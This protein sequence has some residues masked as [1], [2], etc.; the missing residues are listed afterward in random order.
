MTATAITTNMPPRQ[1]LA[2]R[3]LLLVALLAFFLQNF[4]VQTHVHR[5][6]LAQSATSWIS[7][8][9]APLHN[10]QD[11]GDESSCRLCQELAYAGAAL[12]P[13]AILDLL[14][15][16]AFAWI[17]P[18]FGRAPAAARAAPFSWQSRAPPR[19]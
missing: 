2:R 16:L 10:M 19:R 5:T 17:A 11:T 18:A 14:A 1:G 3:A 13:A 9:P 6:D 4:A 7:A 12:T 8:L 15:I